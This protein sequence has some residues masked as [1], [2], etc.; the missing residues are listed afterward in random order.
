MK[1]RPVIRRTAPNYLHQILC[2]CTQSHFNFTVTQKGRC[3]RIIH[4][5]QK[6]GWTQRSLWTCS[7]SLVRVPRPPLVQCF[8]RRTPR[9]QHIVMVM[10]DSYSDGIW[11]NI[12]KGKDT[13]MKCGGHQVQASKSSFSVKSYSICLIFPATSPDSMY[14]MLSSGKGQKTF[15]AQ[16]FQW[17]WVMEAS[18]ARHIPR[19]QIHR[20]KTGVWH[21]PHCL[22]KQSRHSPSLWSFRVVGSLPKS[23]FPEASQRP[24]FQAGQWSQVCY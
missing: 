16:G 3:G 6:R 24:T 8:V 14:E 20:R 22:Y 15:S 1:R 17:G 4:M 12:S 23:K 7:R 13:Q 2:R 11:S 19:F 21:R 5:Y 10:A 18:S 9:T